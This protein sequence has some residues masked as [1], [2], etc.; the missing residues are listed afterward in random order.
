VLSGHISG[1]Y[2]ALRPLAA[3]NHGRVERFHRTLLEESAYRV[4]NLSNA[5]R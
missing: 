3:A 1:L 4:T 5:P 2:T